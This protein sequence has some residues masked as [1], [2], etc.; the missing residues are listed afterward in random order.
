MKIPIANSL[1]SHFSLKDTQKN[2]F[3]F[4]KKNLEKLFFYKMK[5]KEFPS[6]KILRTQS[7]LN[8]TGYIIIN[9]I[10]EILVEKFL[11][12][13]ILYPDI[14]RILYSFLKSKAVKNHLKETR[15]QHINDVFKTYNFCKKLLN[16]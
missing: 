15:I 3:L 9:S 16:K 11:R 7:L 4:Y 5:K 10:N 13:K 12:K 1:N 14:V 8:Q 2:R 6:I